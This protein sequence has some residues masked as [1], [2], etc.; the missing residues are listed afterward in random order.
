LTFQGEPEEDEMIVIN[1]LKGLD[2]DL[3]HYYQELKD[4]ELGTAAKLFLFSTREYAGEL[5]QLKDTL[6]DIPPA[7]RIILL[8]GLRDYEK[9]H[10]NKSCHRV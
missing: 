6:P 1:F 5:P 4:N 3:S 8:K 9:N 2:Q 7:H 10:L